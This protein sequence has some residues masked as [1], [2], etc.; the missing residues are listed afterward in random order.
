M[1]TQRRCGFARDDRLGVIR[2]LFFSFWAASFRHLAA[3]LPFRSVVT[4][5]QRR[6]GHFAAGIIHPCSLT[7]SG[8]VL[9]TETLSISNNVLKMGLGDFFN[10]LSLV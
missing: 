8:Y 3:A 7:F 6:C 5:L 9:H 10:V 4:I 2:G 1:V